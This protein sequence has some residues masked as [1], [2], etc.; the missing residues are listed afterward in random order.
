M[1]GY[2][3]ISTCL[4]HCARESSTRILIFRHINSLTACC[5][6]FFMDTGRRW[7]PPRPGS[8]CQPG[9]SRRRIQAVMSVGRLVGRQLDGNV[10]SALTDDRKM[11]PA[12]REIDQHTCHL[13]RCNFTRD[14]NI[15]IN[16]FTI[17]HQFYVTAHTTLV[18]VFT[19]WH[20]PPYECVRLS[21]PASKV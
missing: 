4:H 11:T 14:D 16:I 7:P 1:H 20:A 9:K 17:S 21:K 15:H 10:Y 19:A 3:V 18:F 13:Y 2:R 5:R 8:T 12:C 6:M